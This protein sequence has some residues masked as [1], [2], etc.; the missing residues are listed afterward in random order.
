MILMV[1]PPLL[2]TSEAAVEPAVEAAVLVLPA[3]E[4]AQPARIPEA[5]RTAL[6]DR[7]SR[8][9]IVVFSFTFLFFLFVDVRFALFTGCHFTRSESPE[10]NNRM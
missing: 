3:L 4:A 2:G 6:M 10:M 9:F 1:S 8:R 5:A 7:N